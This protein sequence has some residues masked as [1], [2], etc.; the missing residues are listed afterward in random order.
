V[1]N[2]LALR[3]GSET[4]PVPRVAT[5]GATVRLVDQA[6][7]SIRRYQPGGLVVV[8]VGSPP[9]TECSTNLIGVHRL[10]ED[11]LA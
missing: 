3:W 10:G 7:L 2:H 5:T 6:M 8:V 9:A 4:I 1:R 11:D